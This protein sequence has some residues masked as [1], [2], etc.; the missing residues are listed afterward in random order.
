MSDLSDDVLVLSLQLRNWG[1]RWEKRDVQGISSHLWLIRVLVSFFSGK[2]KPYTNLLSSSPDVTPSGILCYYGSCLLSLVQWGE[3]HNPH[4][5]LKFTTLYLLV[6]Y[7]LDSCDIS[8]ERKKMLTDEIGIFFREKESREKHARVDK[9]KP[10]LESGSSISSS[11][12]DREEGLLI[13]RKTRHVYGEKSSMVPSPQSLLVKLNEDE[14]SSEGDGKF[15]REVLKIVREIADECPQSIPH[16]YKLFQS[17][18][19]SVKVQS[20][21]T[22]SR[23]Q[24]MISSEKKGMYTTAVIQSLLGGEVTED[25]LNLGAIIQLIDDIIDIDED[26]DESINTIATHD[27]ELDK[28]VMHISNMICSLSTSYSYV[29]VLLY[30]LLLYGITKHKDKLSSQVLSVVSPYLFPSEFMKISSYMRYGDKG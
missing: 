28:L 26:R 4:L 6:D 24:Y 3:V 19:E 14:K 13:E 5:I 18:V 23:D 10:L 1:I 11:K 20:S 29:K 30:Q 2:M 25:I 15:I 7:Y 9:E 27:K 22:R 16:F 12:D 8:L 17:E 21:S